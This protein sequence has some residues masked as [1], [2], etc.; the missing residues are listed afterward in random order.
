MLHLRFSRR[1]KSRHGTKARVAELNNFAAKLVPFQPLEEAELPGDLIDRVIL[2][3]GSMRQFAHEPI[4]FAQ[5]STILDRTTRGVAADFREPFGMQLN[6]LYLIV[7]AVEGLC[8]GA[9][10]FR[11][12]RWNC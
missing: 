1:K 11:G 10:L 12:V 7:H 9:Y 3:R 4:T 5:L 8:P 2:R 6:H